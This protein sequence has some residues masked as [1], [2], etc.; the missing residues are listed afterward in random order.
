MKFLK[1]LF[2]I[3]LIA[4]V[5]IGAGLWYSY[6]RIIPRMVAKA[7]VEDTDPGV[8]P[9]QYVE[10]I[11]R[12]RKPANR[13]AEKIVREIDSLDI[14]FSAFLRLIDETENEALV[15]T[16]T[17]LKSQEPSTTNEVFNIIK[18][19]IPSKEFDLEILRKPFLKYATMD[20]YDQ[21]LQ[22][23]DN[24]QVI[25]QIEEMPFREIVKEVLIQKR[26]EIDQKL[27]AAGGPG[28]K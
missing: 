11:R 9:E 10:K 1:T 3:L 12:V 16:I 25:E 2:I 27:R 4:A 7:I 18:E 26:A 13:A 28:L 24:N 14:P 22:Y 8:L 19:H 20:R 23:I 17:A 15:E 5:L 21:G 6:K